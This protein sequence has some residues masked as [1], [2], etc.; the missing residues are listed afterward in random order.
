MVMMMQHLLRCGVVMQRML[1]R[2]RQRHP[3]L[4]AAQRTVQRSLIG[5]KVSPC[6]DWQVDAVCHSTLLLT[7]A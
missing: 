5:Y 7:P 3:V 6:A 2:G 1:C 4:Q